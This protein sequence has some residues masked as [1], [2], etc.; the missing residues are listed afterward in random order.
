MS[1]LSKMV[2]SFSRRIILFPFRNFS[3][4]KNGQIVCQKDLSCF[5]HL[6]SKYLDMDFFLRATTLLRWRRFSLQNLVP[7]LRNLF[8]ATFRLLK[9]YRSSEFIWGTDWRFTSFD[10]IGACVSMTSRM[11]VLVYQAMS[12]AS[13]KIS[14]TWNG[15]DCR[16]KRKLAPL[17]CL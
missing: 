13:S 15:A 16:S 11:S 10:L 17:K 4:E 2:L 7:N 3:S 6:L 5:L 8:R 12:S 14:T 9:A 1:L